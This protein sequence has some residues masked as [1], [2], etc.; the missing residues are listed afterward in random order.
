MNGQGGPRRSAVRGALLAR[1]ERY[2]QLNAEL[3]AKTADLVR[4]A[5]EVMRDQQEILS[6]PVST[7]AKSYEEDNC[8]LRNVLFPEEPTLTLVHIKQPNKKKSSPMPTARNRSHSGSKERRTTLSEKLRNIEIQAA[9]DVA[10]PED[11]ADFSLAKT[12]SK[13]EG[14]LEEGNLPDNLDDDILPSVGSKIGVEAQI[15]FL[16]AKL[17]VMQEELDNVVCECSKKD[18]ENQNLNS[19]LKD[20]EEERSRLQRTVGVH[21]S[22]IE[23][24]KILSEEA[25][26]KSEGLQQQLTAVEKELEN[27]KRAQKQASTSQS[28]TEVRL[29]RALEEAERYRMELNKLKQNNKD[30]ANQELKKFE[31]LKI[32]NKRL[33]KQKG[34]LMAGFKKQLKLIDILKRQKM[35]IEAAKMLSFTEEEFMKALEW[36]SS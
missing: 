29:N 9:D 6:R 13:I 11:Y 8:H 31:E 34:E 25:N 10:I 33:E 20:T 24:Y 26:R 18:D 7:Q 16:K 15:R 22:Q 23:K 21:Q 32:Q 2:K 12:I 30:I 19:Q 35:H 3:E 17:R 27:L 4:Q 28:A 36:G 1:E 5:E 14:K